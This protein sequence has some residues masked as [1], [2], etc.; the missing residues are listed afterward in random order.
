M[1]AVLCYIGPR[2]NGTLLYMLFAM[3][4]YL[5][6]LRKYQWEAFLC[7]L[8]SGTK[9]LKLEYLW[10]QGRCLHEIFWKLSLHQCKWF[11]INFM[12]ISENDQGHSTFFVIS[13]LPLPHPRSTITRQFLFRENCPSL[14]NRKTWG[15]FIARHCLWPALTHR[16]YQLVTVSRTL[17]C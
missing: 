10:N 8:Y 14:Y 11:R 3:Y 16:V 17:G 2:Y 5:M 13:N 15:F 12:S 1:Y 4:P 7:H 9:L 6:L